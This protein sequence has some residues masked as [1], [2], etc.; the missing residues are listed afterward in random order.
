VSPVHSFFALPAILLALTP[1]HS[2][3]KPL[4]APVKAQLE[5]G[6]FWHKCCP[7]GLSGLRLLT[8]RHWGWDGRAHSGQLI[9]NA[10]AAQPLRRVF[11]GL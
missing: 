9:V 4:P 7:V 10:R 1:F 3:A 5:Q 2:S 11:R 6:G 8:V